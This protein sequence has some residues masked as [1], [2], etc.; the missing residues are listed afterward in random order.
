[1]AE[2]EKI[3][4]DAD[5][6]GIL[7]KELTE[8]QHNTSEDEE[9]QAL[10]EA[11]LD[12]DLP[13]PVSG[14]FCITNGV[15]GSPSITEQQIHNQDCSIPEENVLKDDYNTILYQLSQTIADEF[16]QQPQTELS[17]VNDAVNYIEH[18]VSLLRKDFTSLRDR[19]LLDNHSDGSST[20]S[21]DSPPQTFKFAANNGFRFSP[22]HSSSSWINIQPLLSRSPSPEGMMAIKTLH[23]LNVHPTQDSSGQDQSIHQ[24][25]TNTYDLMNNSETVSQSMFDAWT[26]LKLRQK[27]S[28]FSSSSTDDISLVLGDICEERNGSKDDLRKSLE[29]GTF[30][31]GLI[32]S[33]ENTSSDLNSTLD[34]NTNY[35]GPRLTNCQSDFSGLFNIEGNTVCNPDFTTSLDSSDRF[36]EEIRFQ[37][38]NEEA[39]LDNP[40]CDESLM[41]E[42]FTREYPALASVL[43][44]QKGLGSN[45]REANNINEFDIPTRT[46][47][48]ES[49]TT[50]SFPR[51]KN[52]AKICLSSPVNPVRVSKKSTKGPKRPK[53]GFI[54]F[55]VEQRRL[56]ADEHPRL[57]NREVS[58]MLGA[59]WRKMSYNERQPYELEFKKDIEDLRTTNPQWRYAPLKRLSHDQI[60]PMPSRLRPRETLKR[61]FQPLKRGS[62]KKRAKRTSSVAQKLCF[63]FR[64]YPDKVEGQYRYMSNNTDDNERCDSPAIRPTPTPTPTPVS[65]PA[66]RPT[67]TPISTPALRP[68]PT[69]ISTPAIRPTPTPIS[70]PAIRPTPTPIPTPDTHLRMP[71]VR[72]T[73]EITTPTQYILYR[74]PSW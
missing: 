54:R 49:P 38:N 39:L 4:R 35:F 59:K 7:L 42:Q 31:T 29:M 70:T 64:L 2:G 3:M 44:E 5:S 37:L 43:L 62:G 61:K 15:G 46:H 48:P 21:S 10:W 45:W 19:S 65:T 47:G 28:Q 72:I 32:S 71:A 40:E 34:D 66:I 25:S 74:A 22:E 55:S 73:E 6:P 60:E 69:P 18:L 12:F 23:P 17:I 56:M 36:E 14:L 33:Q 24:H 8:N 16:L 67:P 52:C 26:S 41:M 20:R 53:N 51:A 1:M 13:Y 30:G 63:P 58:R 11:C 68:T 9:R 27:Q 50:A 57:D